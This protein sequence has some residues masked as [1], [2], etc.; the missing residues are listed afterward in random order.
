MKTLILVFGVCLA[1]AVNLT[2]VDVVTALPRLRVVQGDV[3]TLA[4]QFGGGSSPQ[5]TFT[6]QNVSN[7]QTMGQVLQSNSGSLQWSFDSTAATPNQLQVVELITAAE[8]SVSDRKR[9]ILEIVQATPRQQWLQ[10]FFGSSAEVPEAASAADPDSDGR[11]NL[12]EF[13]FGSNPKSS[14]DAQRVNVEAVTGSG[15][16]EAMRAVFRRR[17]DRVTAGLSYQVEF[18]SDLSD[19]TLSESSPSIISE[20]G[21]FEQVGLQFPILPNGKQSRFF[22]IQLQQPITPAN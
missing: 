1:H 16:V 6:V 10:Q 2:A 14:N 3:A 12:E 20:D 9:F 18:S 19:W 8:G 21:T 22:R 4:A 15:A 5:P 11:T 17:K 7:G 13:A